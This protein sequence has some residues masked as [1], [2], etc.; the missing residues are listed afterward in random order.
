VTNITS[1][2]KRPAGITKGMWKKENLKQS[3]GIDKFKKQRRGMRKRH[4]ESSEEKPKSGGF[5]GKRDNASRPSQSPKTTTK[6]STNHKKNTSTFK[7]Q[8][9]KRQKK[10]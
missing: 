5:L 8:S 10:D 9:K 7:N 1:T 3:H 2:K 4:E 6:T